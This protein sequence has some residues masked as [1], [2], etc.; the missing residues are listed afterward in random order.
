MIRQP[1]T[2]TARKGSRI[3]LTGI[4]ALAIAAGLARP[5]PALPANAY[6][7]DAP[8]P[9]PS[10]ERIGSTEVTVEEAA[11]R[12]TEARA[13]GDPKP[14]TYEPGVVIFEMF[15][16]ASDEALQ[17]AL[18]NADLQLDRTLM[19]PQKDIG[20]GGTYTA[21]VPEG[22][23]VSEAAAKLLANTQVKLAAPDMIFSIDGGIDGKSTAET[24][25]TPIANDPQVADAPAQKE[26]ESD[27][28]TE[29]VGAEAVTDPA[30]RDG[31][32]WAYNTLNY[33]GTWEEARKVGWSS[34]SNVTVAV[35]DTGIQID[36]E[37]LQG[38]IDA[39]LNF[40]GRTEPT[41]N[42]QGVA[43]A[44]GHGTSVS[45]I[46][47]ALPNGKGG[48]GISRNAKIMPMVVTNIHDTN[49]KTNGNVSTDAIIAACNKLISKTSDGRTYAQAH[50]VRVVN[51]SAGD[52]LS[53]GTTADKHPLVTSALKNLI[54]PDK[55]NL[56]VVNSAGNL[57]D[58]ELKGGH[59][60][61]N[62]WPTSFIDC[63]GVIALKK[64]NNTDG[65][66][67][68]EESNYNTDVNNPFA[69]LSA[70]GHNIYTTD[71]GSSNSYVGTFKGTS[72]AAPFVSGT[73]AIM[74]S[75]CPSLSVQ[76][77]KQ[78]LKDTATDLTASP[79]SAGCDL[80]TGYGM[81]N[82]KEA[83]KK[84]VEK[85][86]QA[87]PTASYDALDGMKLR[88]GGT[89][90]NE[91]NPKTEPYGWTKDYGIV[92]VEPDTTVSLYGYDTSKWRTENVTTN[93]T[94]KPVPGEDADEP[95]M[96]YT[97]VQTHKLAS[98]TNGSAGTPLTRTYTFTTTWKIPV[99]DSV[100]AEDAIAGTQVSIGGQPYA[101]F[102]PSRHSYDVQFPS[103][104][105]MP[106][107]GPQFT[108]LPAGW[109][110]TLKGEPS[111]FPTQMIDNGDGSYTEKGGRQYV[112]VV[113][114]NGVSVEYAFNYV[115]SQRVEGVETQAESPAQAPQA[116][117]TP[118]QPAGTTSASNG[119]QSSKSGQQQG[120]KGTLL[121]TGDPVVIVAVSVLAIAAVGGIV[122]LIVKK[123]RSA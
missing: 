51:I 100:Q 17:T 39:T 81:V 27:V 98:L 67:I 34:S 44:R 104:D 14:G 88:L 78:I 37:D 79:A 5:V 84:A 62:H 91:F 42:L 3:A 6:A 21:T 31:R 80:T 70:P 66:T 59:P 72:A 54:D 15:P 113:S 9:A 23:S 96:E 35:I 55:G 24:S 111:E 73:A 123:R 11:K 16:E 49:P 61:Y 48:V 109:T 116:S 63:I 108:N 50:N 122:F 75:V 43:D 107:E 101:E 85:Q 4:A 12:S 87:G 102:S 83:V 106:A 99:K 38:N 46:I 65:V 40:Y 58:D 30:A 120:S 117:Q 71:R 74:F 110:A 41:T 56:L 19:S 10:V 105:A 90:I 32:E 45:G 114:N 121:Q 64:A 82:P 103:K 76:E 2:G 8:T 77:A 7:V 47:S 95:L 89:T 53:D 18:S 26:N 112:V 1:K 52:T 68:H 86:M 13:K 118:S 93:T 33:E 28:T 69:Q 36:H 119:S 25:A 22:T 92:N 60:S 57:T 97:R 115:Y 94:S 29:N 20:I